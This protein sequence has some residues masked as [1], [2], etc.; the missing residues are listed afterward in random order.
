MQYPIQQGDTLG[1]I[2]KRFNVPLETLAQINKL[3]DVNRIRAGKS[4]TVPVPGEEVAAPP[5]PV[6]PP[7]PTPVQEIG[8]TDPYPDSPPPIDVEIVPGLPVA[9]EV[10]APAVDV[11]EKPEPA[12][13]DLIAQALQTAHLYMDPV[14]ALAGNAGNP[15]QPSPVDY[16]NTAMMGLGTGHGAI[17]PPLVANEAAMMKYSQMIGKRPGSM[18]G[19][20]DS[21]VTAFEQPQYQRF[22]GYN[23]PMPVPPK[24]NFSPRAEAPMVP[25]GEP[26]APQV[27]YSV[28]AREFFPKTVVASRNYT[29]VGN[30][31]ADFAPW[32]PVRSMP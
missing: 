8:R 5:A 7:P 24:P 16:M 3:A 13:M 4:L 10:T 28:A 26:I 14:R 12:A 6:P 20:P 21:V 15:A 18:P 17:S 1:A 29:P 9:D 25:T 19:G 11:V 22:A 2:A 30:A 32:S 27:P 31:F 23:R